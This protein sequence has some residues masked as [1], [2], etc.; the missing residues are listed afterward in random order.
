VWLVTI[1]D[2][3]FEGSGKPLQDFEQMQYDYILK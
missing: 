1:C 2:Y 3:Y